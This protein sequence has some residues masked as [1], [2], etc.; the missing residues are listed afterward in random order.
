[1]HRL[2]YPN[3]GDRTEQLFNYALPSEEDSSK[4]DPRTM[5][6]LQWILARPTVFPHVAKSETCACTTRAHSTKESLIWGVLGIPELLDRIL[7]HLTNVS[8]EGLARDVM[9]MKSFEEDS[10]SVRQATT[11]LLS[12]LAVNKWFSHALQCQRQGLF[13]RIARLYGWMLPASAQ[14]WVSW[15]GEKPIDRSLNTSLDWRA[16]LITHLRCESPHIKSRLRI[17]RMITQCIRGSE[18]EEDTWHVGSR[19]YRP[20][21]EAPE[22]WLWE[23]GNDVDSSD[24]DID[25]DE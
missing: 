25:P 7:Q 4:H 17:F 24:S 18:N 6:D 23:T 16:Y 15:A 8:E 2:V 5:N 14:D 12:L 21:L 11:T 19:G 22:P 20:G 9:V 13:L 10:L 3:M 1:M